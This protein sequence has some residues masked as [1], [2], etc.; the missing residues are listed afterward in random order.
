M[1]WD[2]DP[3]EVADLMTE[4]GNLMCKLPNDDI[5]KVIAIGT[6]YEVQTM[7]LTDSDR[8]KLKE[9]IDQIATHIHGNMNKGKVQN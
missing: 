3:H 7:S 8:V 2:V 1:H 9:V 6:L 4:I 5:I